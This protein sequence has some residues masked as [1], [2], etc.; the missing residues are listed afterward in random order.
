MLIA[1]KT[2][3]VFCWIYLVLLPVQFA[4]AGYGIMGGDI[5]AHMAFGGLVLHLVIPVLLL[6]SALVGRAWALAGWAFGLFA[7]LTLQIALVEIGRNVEQ[8]WISGLHPAIAFLTWPLV[9]FVLLR[10]ARERAAEAGQVIVAE[11]VPA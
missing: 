8:T 7:V 11:T 5:D 9:Y 4:L 3:V 2:Y 1:R 10:Q 6:L